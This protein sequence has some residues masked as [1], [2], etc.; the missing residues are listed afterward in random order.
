MC[1]VMARVVSTLRFFEADRIVA[2]THAEW[3]YALDEIGIHVADPDWTT[4][5]GVRAFVGTLQRS[6]LRRVLAGSTPILRY[7]LG[8]QRMMRLSRSQSETFIMRAVALF[9]DV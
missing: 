7:S 5:S 2:S 6:V 8:V 1:F 9:L 3:Q 4:L